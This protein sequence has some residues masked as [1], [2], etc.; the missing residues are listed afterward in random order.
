MI[1]ERHKLIPSVY[2][3]LEVKPNMLGDKQA[4]SYSGPTYIS[5][6]S[7]MHI[8]IKFSHFVTFVHI[9][10]FFLATLL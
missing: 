6:R 3:I 7:G 4:V 10:W 9:A 8:E 1:A 2:A 5:I